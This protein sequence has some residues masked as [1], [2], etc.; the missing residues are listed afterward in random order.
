MQALLPGIAG[1]IG[2]LIFA[3][4]VGVLTPGLTILWLLWLEK[5][6]LSKSPKWIWIVFSAMA[7]TMVWRMEEK[8]LEGLIFL[9]IYLMMSFLAAA[10][11][12][13]WEKQKVPNRLLLAMLVGRVIFWI[14]EFF[15]KDKNFSQQLLEDWTGCGMV[16]LLLLVLTFLGRGAFGMGD[17]KLLGLISLYCGLFWTCDCF[18]YGLFLAGAVSVSL[19]VA[20][21]KRWHDRIAFVPFLLMGYWLRAIL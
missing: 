7:I 11:W 3:F 8:D 4:A 10:A 16:L 21:K 18:F 14:L 13:D 17:I 12:I 15:V 9:K 6:L 5:N 1:P 19:L 2:R 20:G